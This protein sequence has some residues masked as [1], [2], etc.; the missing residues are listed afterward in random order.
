MRVIKSSN[1]LL[2]SNPMD[3]KNFL[4]ENP[5]FKLMERSGHHPAELSPAF[6]KMSVEEI[7]TMLQD[8]RFGLRRT[9]ERFGYLG[10]R[11]CRSKN[12]NVDSDGYR[13]NGFNSMAINNGYQV[14]CYGGST[15]VG[16]N[17]ADNQTISS[18]LELQLRKKVDVNVFNFGAGNHTSLHSSLRL[19]DHALSGKAPDL[20]IFLNGFNDCSYSAGGADGILQFLDQVLEGGQDSEGRASRLGDFVALIPEGSSTTKNIQ[21]SNQLNDEDLHN[22]VRTHYA[23]SVSIQNFVAKNFGVRILRFIEPT[24][25]LNCRTEQFLLPRIGSGNIRFDLVKRLYNFIGDH[26]CAKVFGNVELVSLVDIGQ[27]RLSDPLYIDEA[28]FSP[29][30]NEYIAEKMSSHV[31]FSRRDLSRKRKKILG[32]EVK[33]TLQEVV[34]P[35]NYPLF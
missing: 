21:T 19:L 6:P 17:V 33:G 35:Y 13:F 10:I 26:G 34:D 1:K 30:F 9:V 5:I 31:T 28:H 16:Q 18:Y 4:R 25:F 8:N 3:Q 24:A 2:V 12:F 22:V 11:E 27:D 15:T 7:I 14:H 29:K 20:A 23:T 32:K